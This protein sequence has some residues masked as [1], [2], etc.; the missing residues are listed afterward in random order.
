[1]LTATVNCS[2]LISH[3]YF[4]RPRDGKEIKPAAFAALT[5]TTAPR[6]GTRLLGLLEWRALSY[7]DDLM[8][9][10]RVGLVTEADSPR[11]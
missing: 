3:E 5:W 1:M 10:A 9:E 6:G 8:L 11:S 4:Q 2:G 7:Y